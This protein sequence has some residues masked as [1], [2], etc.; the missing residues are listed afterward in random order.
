MSFYWYDFETFGADPTRDRPAQ[1]GGIRTDDEFNIIGEPL[2]LYCRPADDLLPQ[3]EA[4]LITG[5]TPQ[6]A[7]L[8]GIPETEFIGRILEQ[9]SEPNTCVLGFNSLR[10][11]DEVTRHSLYRNLYDPY[12][13]EWQGGNSRWDLIDL[14]RATRLLRPEGLQW[15]DHADGK[16]SF[17]LEDL[18]RA[19]QIEQV[20]AH[21]ALVDVRAT[22]ELARLI[23]Q[24]QP[25]L[26]DYFYQ[27]KHK[28]AAEQLLDL[29]HHKPVLH[30][31]SR[32]QA[33]KGCGAL[34][35]PVARDSVN[36]NQIFVV[37]LSQDP[38]ELIELDAESLNQR[39]FTAQ[40]DL[41]EGQER[42]AI[43]GVHVNRCPILAPISLI[44]DQ[45]AE[46][47]QID[48]AVCEKH[49]RQ[50]LATSGLAEKVLA[51]FSMCHFEPQTDPDLMLYSGGFFSAHDKRLMN[52]VHQLAPE[53]LG[54]Q[55]WIFEDKRL[56]E[57]LF[58]FRARNYPDTL[59]QAEQ[60]QW[61]EFCRDKVGRLD[62]SGASPLNQILRRIAELRCERT[63][64]RDLTIL[65]E[66][67]ACT[68]EQAKVL[69]IAVFKPGL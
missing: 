7:Q 6:Q 4:C 19:N 65:A 8:K 62:A 47:L 5:I 55:S 31:S 67:E 26:F 68:R 23:R 35:M 25:A 38:Q 45:V 24:R 48:L 34:V 16:P 64:P 51:A 3:P 22:I 44:T 69:D 57:M 27:H 20:G 43:K 40:A 14:V 56:E 39:I 58:R 13:R 36:Q 18:T 15:P 41:P 66:V 21:D 28:Q 11:D 9:F 33:E 54:Q 52:R 32:F 12:A 17:R 37:D 29:A 49:W 42:I 60:N 59:N 46:R 53:K 30:V 61:R 10:F 2:E 1:F 50:L 63:A